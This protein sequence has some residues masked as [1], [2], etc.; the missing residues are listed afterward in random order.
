[1]KLTYT[2]TNNNTNAKASLEHRLFAFIHRH[3]DAFEALARGSAP[4]GSNWLPGR[5]YGSDSKQGGRS[6]QPVRP[7]ASRATAWSRWVSR[8]T[9]KDNEASLASR[10]AG[11]SNAIGINRFRSLRSRS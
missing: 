2:H 8:L 11:K 4:F 7:A 1:M 5:L 3:A 10:S 6:W 9:E